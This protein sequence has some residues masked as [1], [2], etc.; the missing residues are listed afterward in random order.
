M[1]IDSAIESQQDAENRAAYILEETSYRLGSLKMVLKGIP[2][3]VPGRF[4]TLQDF[5]DGVSN[6]FYIT[7]VTHEYDGF[8]YTTT[9]LGKASTF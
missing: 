3:L 6:K 5:G 4:I 2:E 1:Y 9:I 7:D 8:N